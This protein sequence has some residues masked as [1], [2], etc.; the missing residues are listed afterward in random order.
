MLFYDM[1][2]VEISSTALNTNKLAPPI[3]VEFI[4]LR[5]SFQF[6]SAVNSDHLFPFCLSLSIFFVP[7]HLLENL[8]S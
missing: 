4:V 8:I 6:F 1:L 3:F 7:C 5:W 2:F